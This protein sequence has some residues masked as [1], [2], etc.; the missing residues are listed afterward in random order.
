MECSGRRARISRS[1]CRSRASGSVA[2]TQ[3]AYAV[4][5]RGLFAPWASTPLCFTKYQ[6]YLR[7]RR[8]LPKDLAKNFW[9]RGVSVTERAETLLEPGYIRLRGRQPFP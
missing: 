4:A 8:W 3:A 2:V 7:T 6:F 9:D 1:A 5:V